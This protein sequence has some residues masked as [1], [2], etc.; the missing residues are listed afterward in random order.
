MGTKDSFLTTDPM[1]VPRVGDIWKEVD[2]RF[3][4]HVLVIADHGGGD[5]KV[6]IQGCYRVPETIGWKAY[7]MRRW[8]SVK[9]FNGRR[10]GY[11]LVIRSTT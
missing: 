7:G 2:P 1:C 5:G 3:N 4:R 6:Q 10:G 9:R 8:A 11:A